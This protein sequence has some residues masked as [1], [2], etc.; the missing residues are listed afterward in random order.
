MLPKLKNVIVL[1]SLPIFVSCSTLDNKSSPDYSLDTLTPAQW[2][3]SKT[4]SAVDSNWLTNFQDAQLSSLVEEALQNNFGLEAA[5]FQTNATQ[6]A[7]RISQSLRLPSLGLEASTGSQETRSITNDYQSF[8]FDSSSLSLGASWEFDVWNRLGNQ[9]NATKAEYQATLQ[10]YKALE[11]S[12]A[13]QVARLWFNA[14]D[15]RSQLQLSQ[16]NTASLESNLSVLENRYDRGLVTSFDIRL[17]RSQ[18]AASRATEQQRS[19]ALNSIVRQLEII[20]GRYPSGKLSIGQNLPELPNSIPVG[21]PADL[22]SRR[23]DIAAAERRLR[24]TISQDAA[25]QANWL[26]S[27]GLT[28]SAGTNTEKLVDLLDSDFSVWSLFGNLTAPLF[29][30]GKLKAERK[31]S[32]ALLQAQISQYKN[33]VLN[34]FA[35]V[36]IALANE[37]NFNQLITNLAIASK[38][39]LLAEEESWK[40]YERGLIDITSVL[41]TQRRSFDSRN[42]LTTARN[43]LIQNRIDLV[44]ALGGDF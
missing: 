6:A 28:A 44:L 26:P 9:V 36:E 25:A 32:E 24:A 40:L 11:L 35:E 27:L 31:Q 39:S 19:S 7:L 37:V 13:G 14:I 4:V 20:L 38:E 34:A 30:S 17:A 1:S 42:Q 12:I 23:P 16:E 21:L 18:T 3:N 10:D 33:T 43:S 22:I 5:N 15:A 29:Q 41:D 2:A 8:E